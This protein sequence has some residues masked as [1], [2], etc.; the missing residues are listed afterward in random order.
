MLSDMSFHSKS[1]F[2]LQLIKR[3]EVSMANYLVRI[4]GE[5]VEDDCLPWT[6]RGVCDLKLYDGA[7]ELDR[8]TPR[9]FLSKGLLFEWLFSLDNP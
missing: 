1:L 9:Q 4:M 2:I 7:S 5:G 8:D 6:N 3:N